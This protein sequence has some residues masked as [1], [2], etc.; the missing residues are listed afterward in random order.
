MMPLTF[1]SE[2]E[3]VEVVRIE[4]GHG[5][6]AKLMEMG[7]IPSA[8][9]KM[10]YNAKGPVIIAVNDSKYAIGKGIASKIIVRRTNG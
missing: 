10:L 3:I 1:A 6:Y 4:G 9:I 2:N 7:I 5:A 8:K